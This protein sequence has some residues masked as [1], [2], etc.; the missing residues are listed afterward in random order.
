MISHFEGRSLKHASKQASNFLCPALK[1]FLS[2]EHDS[3][4]FSTVTIAFPDFVSWL[5]MVKGYVE[6]QKKSITKR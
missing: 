3:T 4:D 5:V 1:S 2:N 6:K